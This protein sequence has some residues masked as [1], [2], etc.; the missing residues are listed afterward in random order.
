VTGSTRPRAALAC[1]I[2]LG[3]S[4][5]TVGI[6]S[7]AAHADP[8]STSDAELFLA[9]YYTEGNLTGSPQI[10]RADVAQLV[11]ALGTTAS[12]PGWA[13]V[14]AADYDH[15]G[16]ITLTDVAQLSQRMIYDDGPF[17][18]VEASALDMQKA[19]NAGVITSVQLTQDYLDRIAAYDH[20]NVDGS[21]HGLNSILD[22]SSQALSEAEAS[23]VRRAA[24][25]WEGMLDGIPLIL[26]D[27]YDTDDMP[28]TAGCQCFA[29]N[30]TATDA[31]MV[32]G[33]RAAGAVV[34]AKASLDEFATG[35]SSEYSVGT[36]QPD[37][38]MGP[39]VKVYS[40]YNLTKTAGGSSGGTGAS[41]SANLGAIGFGTDTGGSIRDP[42]SYNQLVG[43][44]PTVGLTSR[45]GIVPL[46]LTQDTGG[47]IARDVTDAA[48]ALG[49]V[50]A[51]DPADA[52]TTDD[53]N[54]FVP[55]SYTS[56]LDP[57]A[58]Q[59]A[60][61][62]YLPSLYA[63]NPVLKRLFEAAISD[64]EAQGATV[65]DLTSDPNDPTAAADIAAIGKIGSGSTNEFKA[66]LDQYMATHLNQAATGLTDLDDLVAQNHVDPSYSQQYKTRDAVT[67]DQYD[68]W[69]TQ[70]TGDIASSYAKMTADLDADH[71]DAFIY[72]TAALFNTNGNDL[73]FS[74][75]TGMPA[76]T[77]P[78]GQS[79]AADDGSGYV[80]G[81][82]ANIE[83]LGHKY[84][85]GDLIG[86]A[87]AY[88]QATHHRTSP[89]LF[90]P[91]AGE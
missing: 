52:A 66:N 84:D 64:L 15:D 74:P 35:F 9:P 30:Q 12:Q 71:L 78:M 21:G 17:H 38:T 87:Y 86:Y 37:G 2:A 79:D 41:I 39:A 32:T 67:P 27:N 49:A 90:G 6:T 33:L 69:M 75:N 3:A 47:P 44:R 83:F 82:G 5:L 28:T 23:D 72:P 19:M 80:A 34:M 14:E 7:P 81:A 70:H 4:V 91:L 51:Q 73:R 29:N 63:N 11:A 53:P 68:A 45:D 22:T 50:T 36:L 25:Q 58:L 88:E 16:V 26:K 61:F 56:Y 40:P 24:G 31:T 18:I 89:A 55:P 8:P 54:R 48:I 1:A 20:A 77:L 46:A 57:T 60:R 43:I 13:A 42:S 10:D 59:G 85:E 65:V 62:G 76:I